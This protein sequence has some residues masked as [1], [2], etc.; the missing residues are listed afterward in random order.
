MERPILTILLALAVIIPSWPKDAA[1]SFSKNDDFNIWLSS[2]QNDLEK[3]NTHSTHFNLS[4]SRDKATFNFIFDGKDEDKDRA[5]RV[6]ELCRDSK[7]FLNQSSEI[8]G[9]SQL[10]LKLVTL[11]KSFSANLDLTALQANH[12]LKILIKILAAHEKSLNLAT[13]KKNSTNI[14]G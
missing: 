12:P 14:E 11:E 9:Q 1:I 5:L 4:I 2:I 8:S 3:P 10:N 13:E 7:V 6:L